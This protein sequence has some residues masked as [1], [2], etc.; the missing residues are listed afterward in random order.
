[1]ERDD[2]DELR[3]LRDRSKTQDQEIA[4]LRGEASDA[5]DRHRERGHLIDRLEREAGVDAAALDVLRS[6]LSD[7]ELEL[8]DLRALRDALTPPAMPTR[9][10][11]DLAATFL[12]ASN[13]VSGDFYLAAEGP[14]DS[15]LLVVGDVVGHGI[16]AARRAAFVRTTFVSTAPF[17]D[18]PCQLLEWANA[19]LVE[20]AGVG[21]DFVTAAC[22]SFTPADR[23][24]RWAY[25]GHPPAVRLDSGDELLG[26]P[27]G[28][29]LGIDTDL[30]CLN[31]TAHLAAGDGVL[32]YTDGLTEASGR[33]DMFGVERVVTSVRSARALSAGQVVE[34]MRSDA[35]E[36]A[37]GE[38]SDDLCILAVR[39]A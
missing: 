21:S 22:I 12:P 19:A 2:R 24:L 26:D 36:F 38:M 4:R 13:R 20:R 28:L 17:S 33:G 27:P 15:T 7:A 39:A 8:G 31:Q 25:A 9:P 5:R 1:M 16:E 23:S 3:R 11:L 29:P 35:A 10:G 34:R 30:G 18:S 32:L 6:R 14:A 37:P